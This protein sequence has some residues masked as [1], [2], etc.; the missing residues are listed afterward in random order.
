MPASR[1]L[2]IHVAQPCRAGLSLIE[3]LITLAV[4]S[5]LAGMLMPQLQVH[6]PDRLSAGAQVLASDLDY[7]RSLAVTNNSKYRLVFDVPANEYFLDHS[8]TSALLEVLPADQFGSGNEAV[9]KRVTSLAKLPFGSP[10]VELVAVLRISGTGSSASEI[11][12]APHGG[13]TRSEPS[14]IWLGCGAGDG[15]RFISVEV[16][17]TTGLAEIGTV[18]AQLPSGISDVATSTRTF[19]NPQLVANRDSQTALQGAAL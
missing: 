11:E 5:I 13:T 16:N 14:V 3:V 17:P 6:I 7:A 9:D 4:I 19:T 1:K 10:R 2:R 18:T 8:G 15:R 12:F